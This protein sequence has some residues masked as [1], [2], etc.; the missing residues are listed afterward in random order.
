MF[1]DKNNHGNSLYES[2]AIE[3]Q[4]IEDMSRKLWQNHLNQTNSLRYPQYNRYEHHCNT[5]GIKCDVD[6]IHLR[7]YKVWNPDLIAIQIEKYV[8]LCI[9]SGDLS[10]NLRESACKTLLQESVSRLQTNCEQINL[11]AFFE[12]ASLQRKNKHVENKQNYAVSN[13]NKEEE[14]E[15]EENEI[16]RGLSI[17][18]HFCTQYCDLKH[19]PIFAPL[20][21]PQNLDYQFENIFFCRNSHRFHICDENC[22]EVQISSVDN[23]FACCV[24]GRTQNYVRSNVFGDGNYNANPIHNKHKNGS[25]YVFERPFHEKPRVQNQ[26]IR[27]SRSGAASRDT[28]RVN[29]SN[30]T[31]VSTLFESEEDLKQNASKSE[32]DEET[33]DEVSSD[34]DDGNDFDLKREE[35][36]DNNDDDDDAENLGKE[37]QQENMG[38]EEEEDSEEEEEE[39]W[40]D[41]DDTSA[42]VSSSLFPRINSKDETSCNKS[43]STQTKHKKRLAKKTREH[44]KKGTANKKK[45]RRLELVADDS[46]SIKKNEANENTTGVSQ[47]IVSQT[48][49]KARRTKK[50][51]ETSS[52][53][54]SSPGSSESSSSSSSSLAIVDSIQQPKKKKNQ[55]VTPKTKTPTTT[56]P[57]TSSS[58][59][60]R[61][62]RPP[63]PQR[64]RAI[65]K[66]SSTSSVTSARRSL[67]SSSHSLL[68]LPT[69]PPPQTRE[70]RLERWKNIPL[71]DFLL[72]SSLQ[73]EYNTIYQSIS[74]I[75]F[76]QFRR[77][78]EAQKL[79]NARE[80]GV[81]GVYR[82]IKRNKRENR[83][84]RLHEHM[85]AYA[86]EYKK[87]HIQPEIRTNEPTRRKLLEYY[88]LLSLVLLRIMKIHAPNVHIDLKDW[89]IPSLYYLKQERTHGD[90][91]FCQRDSILTIYLPETN[92]V[93]QYGVP[94]GNITNTETQI[95]HAIRSAL[96]KKS[97]DPSCFVVTP[98]SPTEVIYSS[99]SSSSSLSP[100][101][102]FRSQTNKENTPRLERTNTLANTNTL[103]S[104]DSNPRFSNHPNAQEN[105]L[106]PANTNKLGETST[107]RLSIHGLILER[108]SHAFL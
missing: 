64:S 63:R 10:P 29:N 8:S 79:K 85:E 71:D 18:I 60:S 19:N 26:N 62:Q 23:G 107:N 95:L 68:S 45:R 98:L 91:V 46:D 100:P 81:N 37:E 96:E 43:S 35:K 21:D 20:H 82:M 25:G 44:T 41:Y 103:S 47:T 56:V 28:K 11:D 77:E 13:E 31:R 106:E 76:S 54:S 39:E 9:Q 108:N 1:D 22:N 66:E 58:S 87:F 105:I 30:E 73:T 51:K 15:E 33:N 84:N 83:V 5:G 57:R 2:G 42:L 48:I 86:L 12:A 90:I 102:S 4:I 7:L 34:E 53:A 69:P 94:K 74:K 40:K 65:K 50:K 59:S 97:V 101:L 36:E 24:S 93:D 55:R 38:E 52:D 32:N 67:D 89:A 49:K 75:L 78:K 104:E 3:T 61:L 16:P 72:E 27:L 99:S 92:T 70:E 6:M 14:E 88:A 17:I 80:A